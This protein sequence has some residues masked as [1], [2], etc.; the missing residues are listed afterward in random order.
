MH[1]NTLI[2]FIKYSFKLLLIHVKID[3]NFET[4]TQTRNI[5]IICDHSKF[6]LNNI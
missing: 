5:I 2:G 1:K 3:M 6:L 4:S